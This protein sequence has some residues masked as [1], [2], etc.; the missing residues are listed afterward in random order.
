MMRDDKRAGDGTTRSAAADSVNRC[1]GAG[2]AATPVM[3]AVGLVALVGAA[4]YFFVFGKWNPPAAITPIG[5]EVDAQYRL[6]LIVTGAA[7]IPAQLGLAF[8]I[9]R[10]RDRGTGARFSHGNGKL[11]LVCTVAAAVIFLGLGFVGYRAWSAVRLTPPL[12]GAIR[13]EVVTS[14]FVYNFRYPGPDGKFGRTNPKLISPSTGNPVGIDPNDSAGRDD[15]V[16]PTLT[17]PVNHEID[18]L[19][20]SQDVIHS[21]FVRELRLQQD[22]VPG[23][24]V[25]LHFTPQK[26]GRYDIVC[27]QLCGL[28]HY[29]MHSYLDVVSASDY[30]NFIKQQEQFLQ[31]A[32]GQ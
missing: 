24:T 12:P 30:A 4:V 15:I 18:L 29:R 17:V 8:A 23:L 11:E 32:G 13:I 14:Q 22:A 31:Q 25:P 16:V 10:Y 27:T 28:G 20:R 19:I 5:E 6:T 3:L 26:V 7:F 9:L 2:S 21:F 1:A